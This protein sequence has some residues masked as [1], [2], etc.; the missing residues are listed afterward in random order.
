MLAQKL[1]SYSYSNANFEELCND[2]TTQWLKPAAKRGENT[3]VVRWREYCNMIGHQPLDG[4]RIDLD[5]FHKYMK[6]KGVVITSHSG[7][8]CS[9][10]RFVW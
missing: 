10:I 8:D 7:M 4:P 9:L 2:I 6:D 3:Y 1:R 5:S